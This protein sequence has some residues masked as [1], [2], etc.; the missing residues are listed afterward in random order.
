MHQLA[1]SHALAVIAV[2]RQVEEL[3]AANDLE[4]G[5][6]VLVLLLEDD[7]EIVEVEL[8]GLGEHGQLTM[9]AQVVAPPPLELEGARTR[10]ACHTDLSDFAELLFRVEHL[11]LALQT[12]LAVILE[13]ELGGQLH[14][15]APV[16]HAVRQQVLLL[17]SKDRDIAWGRLRIGLFGLLLG[18]GLQLQPIDAEIMRNFIGFAVE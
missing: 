15:Y 14:K 12:T 11:R 10:I 2:G 5:V 4:L 18:D 16:M 8:L 13:H 3:V 9:A 7:L 6:G 17:P 1:K